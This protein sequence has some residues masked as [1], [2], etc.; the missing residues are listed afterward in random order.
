MTCD[1]A[2]N[3]LSPYHDG[4]LDAAV[5]EKLDAHVAYCSTCTAWL[6]QLCQIGHALRQE[7]P[8]PAGIWRRVAEAVER[9]RR[10]LRLRIGVIKASAVAAGFAL[11]VL[12][13]SLLAPSVRP[14]GS[15][16]LAA[17]A[18]VEEL[19][20]D[21]ARALVGRGLEDRAIAWLDRRPEALLLAKV[22]EDA[23]P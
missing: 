5:R 13:Q 9:S 22:V 21:T 8:M 16:Q 23:E 4:E 14:P 1:E 6:T 17:N 20:Q 18:P 3:Y 19:L 11:Y 2:Q 15:S 10:R 7:W 12:G